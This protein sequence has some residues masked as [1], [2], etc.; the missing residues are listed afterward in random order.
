MFLELLHISVGGMLYNLLDSV[1]ETFSFYIFV[2]LIRNT[3]GADVIRVGSFLVQRHALFYST[4]I[5]CSCFFFYALFDERN[6]CDTS[7]EFLWLDAE[8]VS[9]T[10]AAAVVAAGDNATAE[11]DD[12]EFILEQCLSGLSDRN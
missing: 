11:C 4:I 9:N 5:A 2:R 12:A 8:E 10:T 1:M 7:F 3:T 6:G